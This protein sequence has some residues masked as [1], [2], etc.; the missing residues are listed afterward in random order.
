MCGPVLDSSEHN[1]VH[2]AQEHAEGRYVDDCTTI[3]VGMRREVI[4]RIGVFD[5]SFSFGQDIDFFWRAVD[6]GYRIYYDP[7]VTIWHNWGGSREQVERAFKY[8]EARAHLYK[9]H[10]AHRWRQLRYEP[11]V[12]AYPL[13]ILGLPISWFVPFY[14]LLILLPVAKNLNQNPSGLILHHMSYGLGVIVGA[15]KIWPKATT[16]TTT[17]PASVLKLR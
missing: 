8:G 7:L 6:A 17:L 10:W 3:S 11:Y 14:P 16:S 5:P 2:Y 4:N 13:F 9:K 1:I 12:W 15:L